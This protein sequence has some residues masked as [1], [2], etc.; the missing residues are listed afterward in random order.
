MYVTKEKSSADAGYQLVEDD[1]WGTGCA[2]SGQKIKVTGAA[3]ST[4]C[5]AL[6]NDRSDCRAYTFLD[7]I[8]CSGS[9]TIVDR[10]ALYS[11][12]TTRA[13][14]GCFEPIY[15]SKVAIPVRDSEST[16]AVRWISHGPYTQLSVDGSTAETV[17]PF[18]INADPRY[19]GNGAG[20][21]PKQGAFVLSEYFSAQSNIDVSIRI[22]QQSGGGSY[23]ICGAGAVPESNLEAHSARSDTFGDNTM[24]GHWSYKHGEK[25]VG[26]GP[27]Q[28]RSDYGQKFGAGSTLTLRLSRGTQEL[29]FWHN[30][31]PL[32]VAFTGIPAVPLAVC[33]S[34]DHRGDKVTINSATCGFGEKLNTE[35][36]SSICSSCP[37]DTY[38]AAGSHQATTCDTQ[39]TCG[40]GQTISADSKTSKRICS[41]AIATTATLA[42]AIPGDAC[43]TSRDCTDT[44]CKNKRC[45]KA[46][47]DRACTSCDDAGFCD[48]YDK[49]LLGNTGT[50]Q[51]AADNNE[52][53]GTE[54]ASSAECSS[55]PCK[56]R[57]CRA[58]DFDCF[59][60][61]SGGFCAEM[62]TTKAPI[63][64]EI[65]NTSSDSNN[66]ADTDTDGS[67]SGGGL[68]T[69]TI[70]GIVVSVVIAAIGGVVMLLKGRKDA[71]NMNMIRNEIRHAQ[72]GTT[73]KQNPAYEA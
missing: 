30:D 10:C 8:W 9:S 71:E 7:R 47:V 69:G 57:C 35:S 1:G 52:D 42:P 6:C 49:D 3:S 21:S 68:D 16:T 40:E 19:P 33:W 48:S 73:Q 13:K 60:C 20:A 59:A 25:L 72:Q 27:N 53:A 17:A 54:C 41:G 45:C 34:S 18:P 55:G 28:M 31:L 70:I 63:V 2:D 11:T 66:D 14:T 51:D 29:S 22:G 26:V 64:P 5:E 43:A 15:V 58:D 46:D 56:T 38:Q 61:D 32:G 24:W 23:G 39:P 37:P 50:D 62:R 36:T 65:V 4:E 67:T 12:C 44:Q